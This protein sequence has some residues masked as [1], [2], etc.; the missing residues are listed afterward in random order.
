MINQS[1]ERDRN[2]PGISADDLA[3]EDVELDDIGGD[4]VENEDG[5]VTISDDEE[6]NP[7]S[8]F[9]DNLVLSL[10]NHALTVIA[11]DLLEKVERDKEARSKR[12]EQYA[13]GLKRSGLSGDAPGGATFNGASKVVHPI[14]AEASVDF[15]AS[16]IKEL[17]PPDG[18]VKIKIRG[19]E[20]ETK[21][22]IAKRKTDYLNWQL[23]KNI[24]EYR[25]ELEQLLS[26]LPMGGSQ[27]KKWRYDETLGRASVEFVPIDDVFLPFA[28]S[29]FYTAPRV[30]HRQLLTKYQ[31][32]DRIVSE[33]YEYEGF[34]DHE[35]QVP[36]SPELS[37]AKQANDD[38]EGIEETCYNEDGLREILEIY[39][40]RKLDDDNVSSGKNAPYII[41]I[42]KETEKVLSIYRNWNEN[43]TKFKKLDWWVDYGFIPWRGAYKLGLPHLIGSLAI[44]LTGSLRALLDSAHINNAATMLKLKAGRVNGQTTSVEVTQV[45]EIEG[46]A[47]ID[48]IR[49]L[50]MP[51]PFNP[52]SQVLFQLLGWLTEAAKG[53]V[54]TAEEKIA[55]ASN[56]MPVG[57]TLALIEQ[58]SKVASSIHARLHASQMKEMEILCR[59][60]A[61]WFDEEQA[62]EVFG[63]E[64]PRKED[65]LSS[66]DI[67][68]VSD[69]NIFSDAQRFAKW[70][71]LSQ[72]SQDPSVPWNKQEI[73]REGLALMRFDDPDRFLP[74]V[75]KPEMLD[76]VQE[77]ISATKGLPLK[78]YPTQDDLMHIAAHLKF[79]TSQLIQIT[80]LVVPTVPILI[81]HIK[82]HMMQYYLEHSSIA[83]QAAEQMDQAHG[84]EAQTRTSDI[85]M[86]TMLGE[87]K[88]LL[89]LFQ[90]AQ[91][92]AQQAQQSAAPQM[93]PQSQVAM[94]L[95]QA[96]IQRKTA[97][98]QGMMQLKQAE[99]Q[100]YQQIE[101]MKLQQDQASFKFEQQLAAQKQQ[102]D[103]RIKALDQQMSLMRNKQ[104]ND[105]HQ[106]TEIR[107]NHEDNATNI[108][109]EAMRQ[110]MASNA[111]RD[112]QVAE[113]SFDS[114]ANG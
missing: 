24:E 97:Y 72:M 47:S 9:Y 44:A 77:H 71:A 6:V 84:A 18:P 82:E 25:D 104:D 69:P 30:T 27:Y 16:A 49:K 39:T 65:F 7:E 114:Q 109:I 1:D 50:A 73:M 92:L 38:I 76:P 54:T 33:L 94:Q 79:A 80:S 91:Q 95:G 68:P 56:N 48:D 58:G 108:I 3:P 57:T 41:T 62:K 63:D 78:V 99:A 75:P 4:M 105:Q 2:I 66:D 11:S 15:A 34:D 35:S 32:E 28:S 70:Q 88:D 19:K 21:K 87:L 89:P 90:Q 100:Q 46:P 29:N 61:T 42:D 8:E 81:E 22:L 23:T 26:Q 60:N 85:V 36:K 45:Q 52:P 17:F 106:A 14:L 110:Q 103:E 111:Q 74:E 37:D 53:V 64:A 93:D 96:E 43:D 102:S 59:I 101:Q 20:T 86:Q 107:K 40:W 13:D 10:D 12:D 113:Q 83:A 112:I 5:S 31:F 67:Q 55:D 98:D 51:M